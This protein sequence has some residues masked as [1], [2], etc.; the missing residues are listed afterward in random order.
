M[1]MDTLGVMDSQKQLT[2][3]HTHIYTHMCTLH[4]HTREHTHTTPTHVPI[5]A[6]K[7]TW[8]TAGSRLMQYGGQFL[9]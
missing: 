1:Y 4:I 9:E 3:L 7:D 5:L 2:T 8:L 6:G